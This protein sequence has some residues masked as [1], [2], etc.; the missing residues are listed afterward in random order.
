MKGTLLL[1][2]HS[3]DFLNGVCTSIIRLTSQNKMET[4]SGNYDTYLRT[5]ADKE[6]NQLTKYNKEQDDM[7]HIRKFI[8]TCGTHPVLVRQALSKQKIL[9]KMIEAGLTE[10]PIPEPKYEFTFPD[11]GPLAPPV[12]S[13]NEVA[14][15]YSGRPEDYLF[16]KVSFG[17]DTESR[18]ALL[19]PNGAG[20]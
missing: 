4:W 12:I 3:R 17:V 7:E 10:K 1:I 6:K 16:T 15:S 14:F 20:M 8:S 19:G 2:S 5:R 13:F 11:P 18:V 9:D